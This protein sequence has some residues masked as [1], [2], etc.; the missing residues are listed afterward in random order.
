MSKAF[1]MIAGGTG[2][3][4]MLQIIKAI[5]G[6]PDD[7]TQIDLIFANVNAEDI[8]LKEDLDELA[9]THDNFRVHYILN[10]PPENWSGGVGFV[11]ADI[12]KVFLSFPHLPH[13]D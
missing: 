6:N 1:G 2:I 3:T 7:K 10:S 11:T 9:E 4:P 12:I 13:I 8:L 5:L